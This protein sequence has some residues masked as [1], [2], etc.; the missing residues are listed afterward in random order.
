MKIIKFESS[1]VNL[2]NYK[3]I[4]FQLGNLKENFDIN[5][6]LD[7]FID[8]VSLKISLNITFK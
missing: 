7:K 1:G 3:I 2:I 8:R 5:F 6:E 4:K